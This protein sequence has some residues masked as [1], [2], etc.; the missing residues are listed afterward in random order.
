[1][2]NSVLKYI[3]SAIGLVVLQIL[4]LNNVHI[5]GYFSP[6]LYIAVILF[7]PHDTPK[8]A[9]LGL[10]FLMGLVIDLFSYTPGVHAGAGVFLSFMQISLL[11]ILSPRGDYEPGAIPSVQQY[12]WGWFLRYIIILTFL[13]HLVLYTL[14]I[15]SISNLSTSFLKIISSTA[16]TVFLL[17]L[18]Q[19]SKKK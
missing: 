17:I 19:V 2:N 8:V 12:G 11:P 15:F 1:M 6:F 3:G 18:T 16:I 5:N 7:L 4:I 14:E 9:T 13:H 10:G